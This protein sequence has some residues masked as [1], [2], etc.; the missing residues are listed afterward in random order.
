MI[1]RRSGSW[2]S[3]RAVGV[4]VP[5]GIS[6]RCSGHVTLASVTSIAGVGQLHKDA[7]LGRRLG[8]ARADLVEQEVR[9]LAS[10]RLRWKDNPFNLRA[11]CESGRDERHRAGG[12]GELERRDGEEG[13]SAHKKLVGIGLGVSTKRL[14]FRVGGEERPQRLG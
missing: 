14:A 10:P 1:L 9:G 3:T 12:V 8:Q 11:E 4:S 7:K 2:S 5:K 13:L 6:F